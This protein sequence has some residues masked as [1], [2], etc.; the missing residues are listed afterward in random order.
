MCLLGV[1]M[2]NYSDL[3]EKARRASVKD[4]IEK[5]LE[6]R[7]EQYDKR[8]SSD[9]KKYAFDEELYSRTYNY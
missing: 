3:T 8:F 9:S 2:K 7:L 5:E 4:K 6:S 1:G